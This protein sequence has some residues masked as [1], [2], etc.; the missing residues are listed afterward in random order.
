MRKI[1]KKYCF[2]VEG[3][4]EQWY[5]EWLRSRINESDDALCKVAFDS[6]I[7]KNPLSRIKSMNIVG[8][9]EIWHLCDYESDEPIHQRL[10]HE[11][12]DR[13]KEASNS[14]R[15]VTYKF[16]YCNFTFDLWI[17]LHMKNSC[18]SFAH[19]HQYISE[20]NSAFHEHF[21]D[22]DE[23]KHE[24]NF[25]RCLSKMDLSNVIDAVNRAKSIM[26][27]NKR[28]GYKLYKYKGYQY[29]S[30]NPSLSIYEIIEKILTECGLIK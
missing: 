30:E 7:E 22:M 20:I 29:Y 10:F 18:H 15:S 4:T 16:G 26:E 9:T 13:M 27:A 17:I 14:G 2:S 21:S 25:K 5:L 24:K 8:K 1:T 12:M 23:Y 6:K 3:Y 28:N 19:R 11:T